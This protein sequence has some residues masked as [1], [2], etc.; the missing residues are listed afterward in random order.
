MFT[1][2]TENNRCHQSGDLASP[3]LFLALPRLPHSLSTCL[4][5][6]KFHPKQNQRQKPG[7]V[8][9]KP[10]PGGEAR[11]HETQSR[12]PQHLT[13]P[14]LQHQTPTVVGTHAA[15]LTPHQ[16]R[17][18][19]TWPFSPSFH[20][21]PPPSAPHSPCPFRTPKPLG[22]PPTPVAAGQRGAAAQQQD[23][24]A[25]QGHVHV[26]PCGPQ[27]AGSHGEAAGPLPVPRAPCRAAQP[28]LSPRFLP[29]GAVSSSAT[30]G[31]GWGG[32]ETCPSRPRRETRAAS[33][34]QLPPHRSREQLS[35]GLAP[36]PPRALPPRAL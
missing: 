8:R 36:S 5:L 18:L 33:R 25:G 7:S 26:A 10:T 34:P 20:P 13:N 28:R 29:H 21:I 17:D 4:S 14:N 24:E 2:G 3:G 32:N 30:R 11:G 6:P 15:R 31:R 27:G 9:M 23:A 12:K 1:T 19:S 16:H 35:C 22:F